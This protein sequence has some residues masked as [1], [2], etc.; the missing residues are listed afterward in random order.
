MRII[1]TGIH[2]WMRRQGNRKDQLMFSNCTTN[3]S[4]AIA[5][6]RSECPFEFDL[7]TNEYVSGDSFG[8]RYSSFNGH[9]SIPLWRGKHVININ[10]TESE[11]PY[12]FKYNQQDATLYN[13]SFI[14]V[15]AVHV[16]G[17]FSTHHLELKNCTH[18]I[19][20]MPSLPPATASIYLMLCV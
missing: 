16:S 3:L 7:A 17:S 1:E 11:E 5:V 10:E 19:G 20:Y 2:S 18:S 8:T 6:I 15:N 13:I 9:G 14:I 12:S 4:S